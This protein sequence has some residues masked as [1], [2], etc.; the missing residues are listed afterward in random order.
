MSRIL[1]GVSGGI[2][3]YKALEL[4]RLATA[5]G[6]AVRV[7]QTPASRR[8]V[9]E[10]S[11][12]ALTGAPVLVSEFERDPARGAF[13]DQPPPPHEPLSHL[14]LVANADVYVIAPASANTIAK[15]AGGLADNLLSS[16][17]LAATCPLVLA[18][19]MNNHMYEHPATQANL[20]TLRER[21]AL[22][23]EPEVGRLASRGEEGIGRLAKPARILA[24]C[25]QALEGGA[26]GAGATS[27]GTLHGLKVLVTAGG[28]R[29]PIDSVRFVGNSSSGRM[30]F[31]LA[32]A[33]RERGAEVTLVAANVALP[34]PPGV[35]RRDLV[36]AAQLED[37]CELEFPNCDVLL[38]AAAVADFAPA[39]PERGKIKKST[40][41]RLELVLEPTADVLAGLAAQRRDGQ[42]LVGFAA[43]HGERALECARGKLTGKGLDALV[44][45]DISRS[46]IGF[47]VD[48]NEVTILS[49]GAGAGSEIQERHVPRASKAQVA[50]AILDAVESLRGSG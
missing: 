19:A 13:P 40:R 16:C 41:E 24:A 6:H 28:T 38:M 34:T 18:P 50:D 14:E 5:D 20:S 45:N 44:V 22:V 46:D 15:L 1:L 25:V 39:D 32:Q 11:F 8:F 23:V 49:A 26:S 27:R 30:G 42:T 9:G 37:A 12:A 48:A 10:A 7:V 2:A 31:A 29:E 4:V 33:A 47:D 21:G 3:A 43:E 17:A 36:T 35:V